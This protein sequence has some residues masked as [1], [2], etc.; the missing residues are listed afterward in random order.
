MKLIKEFPTQN[1]EI[2]G[3]IYNFDPDNKSLILIGKS[4]QKKFSELERNDELQKNTR[5]HILNIENFDHFEVV[6][7]KAINAQEVIEKSRN[8]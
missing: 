3:Y 8:V 2:S 7:E 6:T 5:A 4:R 1:V